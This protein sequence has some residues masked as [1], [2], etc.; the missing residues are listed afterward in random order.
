[1]SIIANGKSMPV[2]ALWGDTVRAR[3]VV[4]ER[5]TLAVVEIDPDSTVPVH[6]HE[7]EQVGIV[8][9][10]NVQITIVGETQ[11]VGVG[12]GWRIL[13]DLPHGV[14]AGPDGAVV[15]EAF[16]PIRT[17]WDGLPV[18]DGSTFGWPE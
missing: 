12:G 10:G 4:G 16:N 5:I 13:S 9:Q 7:A 3:R 17:D 18:I 1:M 14:T 11:A 6:Q 15:I 2:L 8:I